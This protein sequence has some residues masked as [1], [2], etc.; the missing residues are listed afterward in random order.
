MKYFII[1]L[2]IIGLTSCGTIRKKII[3]KH[4]KSDSVTIVV[5]DTI[6][7]ESLRVDSVFYYDTDTITIV[8]D[9]LTIQYK[10][11]RDSVY[12]SGSYE[13]DTIYI[14]KEVKVQTICPSVSSYSFNEWLEGQ[15]FWVAV[16]VMF[17]LIL[18]F[19]YLIHMVGEWANRKASK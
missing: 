2:A 3:E 13:G 1:L 10:K 6:K 4:C 14:T 5:H 16:I 15:P 11:V 8:K 18:A 12:L 19:L 7:T 9:K 17:I